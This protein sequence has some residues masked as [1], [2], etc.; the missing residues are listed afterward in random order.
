M[1][2]SRIMYFL[3]FGIIIESIFLNGIYLFVVGGLHFDLKLISIMCHVSLAF[4]ITLMAHH[5]RIP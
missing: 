3:S 5:Y 1:S 4:F 2:Y